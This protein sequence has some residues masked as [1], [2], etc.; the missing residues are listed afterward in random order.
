MHAPEHTDVGLDQPNTARM[1]DFYLGGSHNF[2]ADR[3]AAQQI[4]HLTPTVIAAVHANRAFLARAVR[5]AVAEGIGQ[6]LDLGAGI[7]TI[8]ATHEILG[9]HHPTARVV[10]VDTDPVTVE[11]AR[12]IVAD[13]PR[14]G[15]IQAD[16]RDV[17]A[18]LHDPITRRLIDT[19][20]PLG[21]LLGAVLHHL[22]GDLTGLL[23]RY[24]Q[25]MAPGSALILSHA[26]TD[27]A[28]D[29][30]ATATIA[31][32]YARAGIPLHLRTRSE[33]R[34]L[35]DGLDLVAPGLVDADR[36]HPDTPSTT[37]H[38]LGIIVGVGIRPWPRPRRTHTATNAAYG[39]SRRS[40]VDHR[41]TV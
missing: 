12:R 31:E 30:D 2:A 7:P 19:S 34:H 4:C 20:Q 14:V 36:W 18:V 28:A 32:I 5:R 40:R 16:L 9:R 15:V 25:V 26:T 37:D 38:E 11:V 17:G 33:I 29:P 13:Q 10:Y 21:I 3:A 6:F 35:F 22:P 24:R 27:E 39:A 8:G 1:V 23:A 41:V